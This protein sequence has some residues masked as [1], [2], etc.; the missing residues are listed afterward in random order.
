MDSLVQLGKYGDTKTTNNTKIDHYVSTY[1]A[2][3][4]TFTEVHYIQLKM[5]TAHEF[6]VTA[7]YL[8]C[9][10]STTKWYWYQTQLQ[11]GIDV[12]N[13]HNFTSVS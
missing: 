13:T 10:K 5:S 2:Y 1:V 3:S 9:M 7:K 12:P 11:Q 8:S 4:Y 6:I